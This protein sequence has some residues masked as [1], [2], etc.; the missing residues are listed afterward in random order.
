MS[1]RVRV[2]NVDL[3]NLLETEAKKMILDLHAGLVMATPVDTGN[4]RGSWTVDTATLTVQSDCE[5]MPALNNGHSGQAPAGF[6]ETEV[7]RL[8]S[9]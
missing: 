7:D 1:F 8:N 4:A 2:R 6:I 5:Y 9:R 3:S